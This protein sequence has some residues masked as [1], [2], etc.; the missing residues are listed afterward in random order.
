MVVY[1]GPL[2]SFFTIIWGARNDEYFFV[3]STNNILP[4]TYTRK[5]I[6]RTT[7][8]I[9]SKK[10]SS[11]KNTTVY[12]YDIYIVEIKTLYKPYS[13]LKQEKPPIKID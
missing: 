3:L 5:V 11:S 4:T 8:H 10:K 1:L 13:M 2:D 6:V 12:K 7:Y 9:L